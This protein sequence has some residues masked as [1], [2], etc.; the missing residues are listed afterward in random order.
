MFGR[1]LSNSYVW[2]MS[3]M[4]RRTDMQRWLRFFKI[5]LLVGMAERDTQRSLQTLR[6]E[7][8]GGFT[9]I[10]C[11]KR[12]VPFSDPNALQVSK[13][14]VVPGWSGFSMWNWLPR[15]T[16]SGLQLRILYAVTNVHAVSFEEVDRGK[17]VDHCSYSNYDYCSFTVDKQEKEKERR[18]LFLNRH[19]LFQT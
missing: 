10:R 4:W 8:P 7:S 9:S 16:L 18:K 12:S 5:W 19:V 1:I 3:Q 6:C 15:S 17:V 2:K 11:F 14:R 13:G